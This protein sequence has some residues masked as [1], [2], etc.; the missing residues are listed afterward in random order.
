MKMTWQ[1]V[2]RWLELNAPEIK[3]DLGQGVS[4]KKVHDVAETIGVM[5]PDDVRESY[6]IH[7]GQ[8]GN[9]P[10]LMGEWEVFDLD[11]M[12]RQ[13]Q[14]MKQL[15]DAGE[16]EGAEAEARGPVRAVWWS[17]KWIPICGNGAGDL[18]CVDVDPLS[19]G[20]VGQI[21]VFRH[22]SGEREKLADSWQGLLDQFGNE[23]EEGKYRVDD[24]VLVHI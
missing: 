2:E 9:A 10:P 3:A 19:S 7:D 4:E 6:L 23:L 8:Q 18:Y 1:R 21:V 20:I 5:L 16:F 22:V 12:I 13:W 24:G 11:H 15:F 14:L 17:T